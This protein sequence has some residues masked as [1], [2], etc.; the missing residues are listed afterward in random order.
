M[1][2]SIDEFY[3]EAEKRLKREYEKTVEKI[4]GQLKEA[5]QKA[6]SK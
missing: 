6:L 1:S 3:S 5:K 4:R 2:E